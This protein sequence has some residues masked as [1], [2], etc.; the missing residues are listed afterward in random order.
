MHAGLLALPLTALKAARADV[1]TL[2]GRSVEHAI[3]ASCR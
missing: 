3:P 1:A 2:L